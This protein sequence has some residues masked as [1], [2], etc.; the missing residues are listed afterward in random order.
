MA[1]GGTSR[2]EAGLLLAPLKMGVS[3]PDAH[4]AGHLP[5]ACQAAHCHC[6]LLFQGDL[7]NKIVRTPNFFPSC[8][9]VQNK[10]EMGH[11]GKQEAHG[12]INYNFELKKASAAE[13][14]MQ[15]TGLRVALFEKVISTT[16]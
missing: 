16:D 4:P 2:E 1:A 7:T 12:G 11:L 6:P 10:N 14:S 5:S 13:S 15:Q 8:L 3:R 9:Y